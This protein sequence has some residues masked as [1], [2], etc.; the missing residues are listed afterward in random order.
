MSNTSSSSMLYTMGM[1]LDRAFENGYAVRVLIDGSWLHGHIAAYD[2]V[3][4]VMESLEGEHSVLK[5]ERIAAVTV[6]ADLPQRAPIEDRAHAM[7]GPRPA[8]ARASY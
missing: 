1:A 4:L 8:Y 6:C 3:G 5:S 2:G 7:P